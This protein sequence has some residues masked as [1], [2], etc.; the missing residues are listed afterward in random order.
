MPTSTPWGPSQ[1]S[2]QIARGI[3]QYMTAGHGGIH[4]ARTR[5]EKVPPALLAH[6]QRM[7]AI[8]PAG[9]V[10]LEEDAD[11]AFAAVAFP[12]EFDSATVEAADKTLRNSFPN[13]W[14]DL[15]GRKLEPGE[16]RVRDEAAFYEAHKADF[17]VTAAWGSWAMHV[18]DG[19]VGVVAI[20]G[21]WQ[22]DSDNTKTYWLIP[23]VEY[24]ARTYSFVVDPLRHQQLDVVLGAHKPSPAKLAA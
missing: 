19:M 13:A 22:K 10:W 6:L 12:S 11:W 20:K 8:E 5:V 2:K 9:D 1:H 15:H 14:E 18:P 16:S 4:L 21:G 3:V 7:R 23:E 17:I 24:E